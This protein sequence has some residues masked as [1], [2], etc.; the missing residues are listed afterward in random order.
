MGEQGGIV[1]FALQIAE[2]QIGVG[3]WMGQFVSPLY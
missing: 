1:E 2:G 3:G